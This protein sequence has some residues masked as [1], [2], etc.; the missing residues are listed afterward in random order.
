M[1]HSSR[2]RQYPCHP[3]NPNP[4]PNTRTPHPM[5][6]LLLAAVGL[7]AQKIKEKREDRKQ[8]RALTQWEDERVAECRRKAEKSEEARGERMRNG[9]IGERSARRRR[10]ESLEREGQGILEGEGEAPPRYEEVVGSA[11][12]GEKG[13][14]RRVEGGIRWLG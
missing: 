11:R 2:R 8:K 9:I 6:M 1:C 4:N 13:G 10:S 5:A 7:S 14:C 3:L 12:S